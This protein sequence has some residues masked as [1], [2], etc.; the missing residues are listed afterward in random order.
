M[1]R[2]WVRTYWKIFYDHIR[3]EKIAV[4]FSRDHI[5]VKAGVPIEIYRTTTKK[6][7]LHLFN[8]RPFTNP[9]EICLWNYL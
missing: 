5:V 1:L 6:T 8:L 3:R 7:L 2:W 9:R 4:Y